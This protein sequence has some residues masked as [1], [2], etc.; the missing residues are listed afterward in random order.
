MTYA[1]TR[2]VPRERVRLAI[3]HTRATDIRTA[4]RG[5]LD[6]LSIEE[7]FNLVLENFEEF[8]RE[9]LQ[10]ALNASL[11]EAHDV[12]TDLTSLHRLNRRLV[13]LL[14]TCRLYV[15]QVPH[16]LSNLFGSDSAI[17][18]AFASAK[19][20]EYDGKLGYRV[21]EAMRN[22]I[23]HRGLPIHEILYQT[24][25]RDQPLASLSEHTLTVR[26]NPGEYREDGKFKPKVLD[27]LEQLGEQIELPPLVR[28]YIAGL[29]SVHTELRQLLTE[30]VRP[31][32]EVVK[33]CGDDFLAAG[34]TTLTGLA[35]VDIAESG[36][37]TTVVHISSGPVLR[38]QWLEHKNLYVQYYENTLVAS[39]P[40]A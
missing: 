23:Q 33:T 31:W 16:N 29:A 4:V 25:R 19:S 21:M 24:R 28:Q 37:C 40:T 8:E 1:L 6:T 2:T 5:V 10:G 27:E 3:P 11:F 35:L 22:Y 20:R 34:A 18:T 12:S 13:N 36:S 38:R 39:R 32:D 17:V 9:L 7:K 26:V 30:H 15:D 14:A